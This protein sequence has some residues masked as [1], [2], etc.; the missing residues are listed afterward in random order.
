MVKSETVFLSP[1]I[2]ME[3]PWGSPSPP[4]SPI[5]SIEEWVE[6][7]RSYTEPVRNYSPELQQSDWGSHGQDISYTNPSTSTPLEQ[8]SERTWEPSTITTNDP[9][10]SFGT[11]FTA[12]TT[13]WEPQQ[14]EYS[15]QKSIASFYSFSLSTPYSLHHSRQSS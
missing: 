8:E 6:P 13:D 10:P 3:N 9:L 4:H 14:Y 15:Q 12:T 11:S 2:S 5:Q 1:P 7:Q